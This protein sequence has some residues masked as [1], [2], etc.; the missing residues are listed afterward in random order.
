MNDEIREILSLLNSSSWSNEAKQIEDYITNLQQI[1]QEHK[2][3]NGELREEN[4]K[5]EIA[6]Q[7]IQEDYNKRTKE[8]DVLKKKLDRRYYKN[9]CKRLE[10]ENE[11]LKQNINKV[12]ND[13]NR[14]L[15]ARKIINDNT[16]YYYTNEFYKK[17]IK[18]N[19]AY[20]FNDYLEYLINILQK[21]K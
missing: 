18:S 9:E 14:Y 8:I 17:P 4:S 20:L 19:I 3:I 7:N 15:D 10:Q 2:K 16:K 6:L 1:E 12:I 21:M 5:L 13:I 11:E